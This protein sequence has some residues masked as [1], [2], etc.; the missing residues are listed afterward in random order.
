MSK[1][2]IK[3]TMVFWKVFHFKFEGGAVFFC[4]SFYSYSL[5]LA[6]S[7]FFVPNQM[8]K[9]LRHSLQTNTQRVKFLARNSQSLFGI[10]V[11]MHCARCFFFVALCVCVSV[12][13]C[14]CVCLCVCAQHTVALFDARVLGIAPKSCVT[15]KSSSN[16][17]SSTHKKQLLPFD[18]IIPADLLLRVA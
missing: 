12:C 10:Y 5:S 14:V 6:R 11:Q 16:N 4:F 15:Q 7:R 8:V 9:H 1:K 3:S 18:R 13:E 2:I 17:C